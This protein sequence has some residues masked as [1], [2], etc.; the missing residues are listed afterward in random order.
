MIIET[1]ARAISVVERPPPLDR[2]TT[3]KAKTTRSIEMEAFF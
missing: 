3:K 2:T 1:V